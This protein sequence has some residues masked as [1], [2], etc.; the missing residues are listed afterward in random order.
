MTDSIRFCV[1]HGYVGCPCPD[2]NGLS[3][4]AYKALLRRVEE[5][6]SRIKGIDVKT[7]EDATS[8][9]SKLQQ[10]NDRL[11]NAITEAMKVT[12]RTSG[13]AF[14]ERLDEV[15]TILSATLAPSGEK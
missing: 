4:E 15:Y 2:D 13:G 8:Y 1:N 5:L 9:I 12:M 14:A 10:Q 3:L 7:I 11:R 6:E